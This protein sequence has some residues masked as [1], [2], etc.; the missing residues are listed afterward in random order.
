MSWE[1]WSLSRQSLVL[2]ESLSIAQQT[3]VQILR[4]WQS[5]G[6][7]RSQVYALFQQ[8]LGNER[9]RVALRALER[10]MD[11]IDQDCSRKLNLQEPGSDLVTPDERLIAELVDQTLCPD[12]EEALLSAMQLVRGDL[13]PTLLAHFTQLSLHLRCVGLRAGQPFARTGP[14]RLH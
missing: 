12:L 14:K 2:I 5:G 13:A 8:H 4:L 3:A 11:L 9:A 7:G 10:G 6:M 1:R